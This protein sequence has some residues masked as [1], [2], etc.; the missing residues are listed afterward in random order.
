MLVWV[1]LPVC[2]MRKGKWASRAPE[3][4]SRAARTMRSAT[5]WSS[6]PSSALVRAE[7]SFKMPKARRRGRGM[8]SSPIGKW[9]SD[10]AVCAPQ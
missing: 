5:V 7:A 1:P 8:T 3:V 10:R 6:M 2:Q 9:T 4:T